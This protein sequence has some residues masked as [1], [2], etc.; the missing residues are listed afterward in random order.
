MDNDINKEELEFVHDN[1]LL[2]VLERLGIKDDF[3]TGKIKCVFCGD[4]ITDE[5]LYSFFED[6]GIKV[7]CNKESCIKDISKK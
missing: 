5:N 1:D 7:S 2:L 6:N 4:T 3:L